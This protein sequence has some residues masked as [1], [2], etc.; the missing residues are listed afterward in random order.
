MSFPEHIGRLKRKM[1]QN[2]IK[3][4]QKIELRRYLINPQSYRGSSIL[5]AVEI[6]DPASDRCKNCGYYLIC[7]NIVKMWE[8]GELKIGITNSP[9]SMS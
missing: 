8:K 7:Y 4:T 3:A 6:Y 1:E 2:I 9:I 5:E